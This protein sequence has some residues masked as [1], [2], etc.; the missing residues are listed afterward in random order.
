MR[1]A[2]IWI[3]ILSI[4][5]WWW[6]QP[7]NA[8]RILDST[9]IS[10]DHEQVEHEGLVYTAQWG[11]PTEYQGDLRVLSRA[12][13]RAAPFITHEAVV[14]T[15]QF[16]NPEIVNVSPIRQGSMVWTAKVQPQGTL[17][18]LHF[19]PANHEVLAS[20][21][22]LDSGDRAILE[23]RE[24]VDQRLAADPQH[25][26]RLTHKNHRFLLLTSARLD[27]KPNPN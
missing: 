8:G 10:V 6:R 20:L 12:Y 23:G 24:I 11:E 18:V 27:P 16:S 3:A 4:A 15:G 17:I 21:Q 22:S 13:H 9:I 7:P 14:T 26:I 25:S 1:A 19:I 2:L 5:F